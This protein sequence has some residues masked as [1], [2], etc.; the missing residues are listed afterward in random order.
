MNADGQNGQPQ[1]TVE[2]AAGPGSRAEP[3]AI[4][5]E[6]VI[7]PAGPAIRTAAEGA[8]LHGELPVRGSKRVS[9]SSIHEGRFGRMFRRLPAMAP[10]SND[11]LLTL[12]EQMREPTAPSGWD[13]SV[14]NFDNPEIPSGY[15]YFGQFIDHDITF[16]PTSTLQRQ[17]DPDALASARSACRRSSTAPS[18]RLRT[19][20]RTSRASGSR[21]SVRKSVAPRATTP[22]DGQA[23]NRPGATLCRRR[24]EAD[25][26]GWR[27][28]MSFV[29]LS[30]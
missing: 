3:G 9:R 11:E 22:R 12:S 2:E 21:G 26:E 4:G 29:V 8:R 14:Q 18:T 13:G 25:G 30:G 23:S 1:L 5:D 17:N 24:R 27:I 7:V 16:D 28:R 20:S 15:T 10:L 6:A 19:R